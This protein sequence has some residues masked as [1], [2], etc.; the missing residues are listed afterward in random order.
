MIICQR[1]DH[2][3]DHLQ[4]ACPSRK[5][6]ASGWILRIIFVRGRIPRMIFCK[7]P[8]PPD[9]LIICNNN[10]DSNNDND[11]DNNNDNGNDNDINNSIND[12]KNGR[13]NC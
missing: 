6:F 10:K 5:S 12:R 9:D 4:V 8:D 2:P 7:R 1:P 13:R 11:N 3:D